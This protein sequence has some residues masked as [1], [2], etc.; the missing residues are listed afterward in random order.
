MEIRTAFSI[1]ILMFPIGL[2][3]SDYTK[4][5]I[6]SRWNI[7]N[8]DEVVVSLLLFD[9][10]I[11]EKSW[12]HGSLYRLKNKRTSMGELIQFKA[13]SMKYIKQEYTKKKPLVKKYYFKR[14][15]SRRREHT[16]V[17]RITRKAFAKKNDQ[18][19]YRGRYINETVSI[20]FPAIISVPATVKEHIVASDNQAV[21][22]TEIV[23][24]KITI[25]EG[26]LDD[27]KPEHTIE[28]KAEDLQL[29][30][31]GEAS[32]PVS[33]KHIAVK[34][35]VVK[36]G[37]EGQVGS[38]DIYSPENN[39]VSKNALPSEAS[40]NITHDEST[41]ESSFLKNVIN[42]IFGFIVFVLA[43]LFTP[44]RKP[45]IEV[46]TKLSFFI[47]GTSAF[48]IKKYKKWFLNRQEKTMF[49][50]PFTGHWHDIETTFVEP[51]L[52]NIDSFSDDISIN[53]LINNDSK[54]LTRKTY[55]V[56]GGP[57]YG[58]SSL[59][60][61]LALSIN[62]TKK[63]SMAI[64]CNANQLAKNCHNKNSDIAITRSIEIDLITSK[65]HEAEKL[66]KY[67]PETG[68]LYLF[69]DG[70]DEVDLDIFNEFIK[71]LKSFQVKNELVRILFSSRKSFCQTYASTLE[72]IG[73][74]VNN[75]VTI[76]GYDYEDIFKILECS[77]DVKDVNKFN[78]ITI[79]D[80]AASHPK[81]FDWLN[82]CPL[83]IHALGY[84]YYD[85]KNNKTSTLP[86]TLPE[87]FSQAI[88]KLLGN[89][90]IE[91]GN[92]H[93][94]IKDN[95]S[96][97]KLPMNKDT[98]PNTYLM[99][100]FSKLA[101][102]VDNNSED[103]LIT[104]TMFDQV[105]EQ[106]GLII[107][108]GISAAADNTGILLVD[109]DKAKFV[110][111][112]FK[113]YCLAQYYIINNSPV[114]DILR[115]FTGVK[116]N[117]DWVCIFIMAYAKE[118]NTQIVEYKFKE[119]LFN[120]LC[121]KN[122]NRQI[123]QIIAYAGY[124]NSSAE[125]ILF[126]LKDL[127]TLAEIMMSN[128]EEAKKIARKRILE[129]IDDN[130]ITPSIY[131]IL[132]GTCDIELFNIGLSELC[133]VPGLNKNKFYEI[134]KENPLYTLNN[135]HQYIDSTIKKLNTEGNIHSSNDSVLQEKISYCSKNMQYIFEHD[136]ALTKIYAQQLIYKLEGYLKSYHSRTNNEI[137]FNEEDFL[138]DLNK[139]LTFFSIKSAIHS[140]NKCDY[141]LQDERGYDDLDMRAQE[142]IFVD[143]STDFVKFWCSLKTIYTNIINQNSMGKDRS[144]L[145]ILLGKS[146][147]IVFSVF[148]SINVKPLARWFAKMYTDEI[149]RNHFDIQVLCGSNQKIT[150]SSLEKYVD[151]SDEMLLNFHNN[152]KR[153]IETKYPWS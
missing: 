84:L 116:E 107:T 94:W 97:E 4:W 141:F 76:G 5:Y 106:C 24:S 61:R 49:R 43:I 74:G 92:P 13:E 10:D 123:C 29:Q 79:F 73:V 98:D 60:L 51:R 142:K 77:Y 20:I 132:L 22:S 36:I 59:L 69:I 150:I 37:I 99:P 144:S 78:E 15:D 136:P 9:E 88:E 110:H 30:E 89:W 93:E 145:N 148:L 26:E 153:V 39:E 135:L 87:F 25:K 58:K 34:S 63:Q 75:I 119:E 19:K 28:I 104:K 55:V 146:H 103:G 124:Y 54:V 105:T 71:A 33:P 127:E 101:F 18:S 53:E 115:R 125:N 82:S 68:Q 31:L 21:L 52:T 120:E 139:F 46:I 130:P 70:L 112:T 91:K 57:G 6:K 12:S 2:S 147:D 113:E 134:T 96:G 80:Y 117:M 11:K 64:Y 67:L 17:F 42:Y 50:A 90:A 14:I 114:D 122:Q 102:E 100:L 8:A 111:A 62:Q 143:A 95:S 45:F 44:V 27:V 3:A 48:Y 126:S 85:V 65:V 40:K 140:I 7:L 56:C 138:R 149:F 1:I 121:Q 133:S 128:V 81:M 23:N 47:P 151:S 72:T 137:I 38:Q 35:N 41:I 16:V 86:Q 66:I 118:V 129:I 109:G 131:N 83:L 108:K 152:L 32:S